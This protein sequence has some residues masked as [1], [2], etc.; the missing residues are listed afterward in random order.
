MSKPEVACVREE[1]LAEAS[2]GPSNTHMTFAQWKEKWPLL[3]PLSSLMLI[4]HVTA[5]QLDIAAYE[6]TYIDILGQSE[7]VWLDTTSN[8][9]WSADWKKQ[10]SMLRDCLLAILVLKASRSFCT[11]SPECNRSL[12]HNLNKV[13]DGYE[14]YLAALASPN[15]LRMDRDEC[16]EDFQAARI[17]QSETK[18]DFQIYRARYLADIPKQ[19]DGAAPC[20]IDLEIYD[21]RWLE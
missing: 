7:E 3:S 19:L 6:M 14:A 21:Y 12:L 15:H 9:R 13:W 2:A 18:H 20:K 16:I 1:S 4:D 10:T 17:I 11:T 5:L 8:T